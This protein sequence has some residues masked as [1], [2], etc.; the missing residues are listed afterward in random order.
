MSTSDRLTDDEAGAEVVNEHARARV[1]ASLDIIE[2]TSRMAGLGCWVH[3]ILRWILTLHA[4]PLDT[5]HAEPGSRWPH[6]K[7]FLDTMMDRPAVQ[8]AHQQEEIGPPF[9][10]KRPAS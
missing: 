6:L 9:I 7:R 4:L 1:S 8:R 3:A 2:S 10:A 5:Q